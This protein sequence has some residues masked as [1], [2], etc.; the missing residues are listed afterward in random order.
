MILCDTNIFIHAFNGNAQTIEEINQI[1]HENIALST[2]TVMELHTYNIKDFRATQ[3]KIEVYNYDKL[4]SYVIPNDQIKIIKDKAFVRGSVFKLK[5]F[6]NN[7][8][9]FNQY[10]VIGWRD[11][12]KILSIYSQFE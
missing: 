3:V 6:Q 12:E 2:I 5:F 10:Q 9:L 4:H 1:G 7:E 8:L 11:R